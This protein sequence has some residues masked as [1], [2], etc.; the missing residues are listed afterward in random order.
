MTEE[1]IQKLEQ[2]HKDQTND[3]QDDE[4]KSEDM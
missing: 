3:H 1:N 4:K 2:L